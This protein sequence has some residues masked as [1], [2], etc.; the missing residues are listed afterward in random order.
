M[1]QWH[2]RYGRWWA[3]QWSWNGWLGLGIHIDWRRRYVDFHFAH[4]ILSL[5]DNP[6]NLPY[7]ERQAYNC[8]GG[9]FR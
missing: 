8:R 4:C 3:F 5:G 9:I 7:E 2:Q 1:A 6:I